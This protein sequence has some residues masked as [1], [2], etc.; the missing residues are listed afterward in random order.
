MLSTSLAENSLFVLTTAIIFTSNEEST[1]LAEQGWRELGMEARGAQQDAAPRQRLQ[2]SLGWELKA[3]LG[4][5]VK[6][7]SYQAGKCEGGSR[8]S[9]G[10]DC[11]AKT[12]AGVT[13]A[14]PKPSS[15]TA[16]G[17]GAQTPT[18]HPKSRQTQCHSGRQKSQRVTL[19]SVTA[20]S[21]ALHAQLCSA[22]FISSSLSPN[23]NFKPCSSNPPSRAL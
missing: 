14:L 10:I 19:R 1:P 16:A 8:W 15:A 23:L 17:L 5:Q 6:M 20:G 4:F 21:K 9:L 11:I 2:Q 3:E 7:S 12:G 18:A 13:P 22:P